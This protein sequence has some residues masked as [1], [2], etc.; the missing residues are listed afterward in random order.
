MNNTWCACFP[1]HSE[2]EFQVLR[3]NSGIKIIKLMVKVTNVPFPGRVA[4]DAHQAMLNVTI[5]DALKYSGVRSTVRPVEG[6]R[7]SRISQP[8][9]SLMTCITFYVHVLCSSTHLSV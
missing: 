3:F 5:P 7:R 4:E 1:T 2:G 8:V 6:S 9:L